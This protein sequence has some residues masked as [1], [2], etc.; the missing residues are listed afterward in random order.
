MPE[1]TSTEAEADDAQAAIE[2]AR[3]AEGFEK[4]PSARDKAETPAEEEAQGPEPVKTDRYHDALGRPITVGDTADRLRKKAFEMFSRDSR[5][6]AP[7]AE[8]GEREGPIGPAPKSEV[9]AG[10]K[11]AAVRHG[12]LPEGTEEVVGVPGGGVAAL[13]AS[14][15]RI[16]YLR[17]PQTEPEPEGPQ[18]REVR[19]ASQQEVAGL[20]SGAKRSGEWPDDAVRAVADSN[21]GV[22]AIRDDGTTAAWLRHPSTVNGQFARAETAQA[23]TGRSGGPAQRVEDNALPR[24]TRI[25]KSW[26]Q[27][28]AAGPS[29]AQ[30]RALWQGYKDAHASDE[31]APEGRLEE[32]AG[33][34]L[35][36]DETTGEVITSTSKGNP[37]DWRD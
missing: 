22:R 27:R 3:E 30:M 2:A 17:E 9:V 6:D 7:G 23:G 20:V 29:A 4:A 31:Q 14:G 36:V 21:G 37:R 34:W 10:V 25:A 1:R 18:V 35:I 32:D 5:S 26:F 8:P 16:T 19:K 11:G 12:N 28:Q 13:D 15:D 33:R 24:I